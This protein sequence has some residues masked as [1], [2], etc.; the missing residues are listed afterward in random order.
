MMRDY[1]SGIGR[2]VQSD[3][4]GLQGGINTYLYVSGNPLT[5]VDPDGLQYL[6]A[7][8]PPALGDN[9]KWVP[10]AGNDRG[11]VFRDPM[12]RSANWDPSGHWDVWEKDGTRTRYDRWG[13]VTERHRNPARKQSD[14]PIVKW[15]K[16]MCKVAGP[17]GVLGS[18]GISVYLEERI[19]PGDLMCDAFWG[20]SELQ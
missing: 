8:P 1:D 4:I 18:I 13:N 3:P 20:C 6:G 15:G 11:G 7:P 17:L 9:W 16:K 12:G 14:R 2:Y 5:L 10:N 19:S